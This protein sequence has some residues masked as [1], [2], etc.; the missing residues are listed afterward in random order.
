MMGEENRSSEP[1]RMWQSYLDV[2][3]QSRV[4]VPWGLH[5]KNEAVLREKLGQLRTG[6]SENLTI[7]SDFDN[8]ISKNL[9]PP[10]LKVGRAGPSALERDL[11]TEPSSYDPGDTSMDVLF[12]GMGMSQEDKEEFNE[13]YSKY[14]PIELDMNIGH[15]E[16]LRCMVAWWTSSL[17]IIAR[18]GLR[19]SDLNEKVRGSQMALRCGILD[20]LLNSQ[21]QNVPF[22]IVSGGIKAIIEIAV[23]RMIEHLLEIDPSLS[24]SLN[25]ASDA[26]S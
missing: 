6:G 8:T 10:S 26:S 4:V 15:D 1:A 18:Q 17:S 14:R 21:S 13:N 11:D 2:K 25:T 16:K 24:S 7:V 20:I 12:R 5:F 22:V 9:Y 3:E 19:L 23:L